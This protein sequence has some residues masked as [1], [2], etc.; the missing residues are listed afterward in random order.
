[1]HDA[2]RIIPDS[3]IEIIEAIDP[4][5]EK[6]NDYPQFA[7]NARNLLIVL[8]DSEGEAAGASSMKSFAEVHDPNHEKK[9]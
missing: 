5:L 9:R 2:E 8:G 1:M 4:I 7:G 6:G 3:P